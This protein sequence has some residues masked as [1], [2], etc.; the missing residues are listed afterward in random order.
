MIW[1]WKSF[2][3]YQPTHS[4]KTWL[5]SYC[6]VATNVRWNSLSRLEG[7]CMCVIPGILYPAYNKL[8]LRSIRVVTWKCNTI[9]NVR[10]LYFMERAKGS[11]LQKVGY[12]PYKCWRANEIFLRAAQLTAC[13]W[14]MHPLTD[15]ENFH[16]SWHIS[17]SIE[18]ALTALIHE[19]LIHL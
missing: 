18:N 14:H 1:H 4:P 5:K 6:F 2:H 7:P 15:K 16:T 12:C 19:I 10:E 3:Y 17:N 8:I 9:P 13:F 11:L